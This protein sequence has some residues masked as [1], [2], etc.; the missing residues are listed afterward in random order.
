MVSICNLAPHL[1][2]K[3]T[4]VVFKMLH[5]YILFIQL[6]DGLRDALLF[7]QCP[8]V[9]INVRGR[10]PQKNPTC[11]DTYQRTPRSRK[12]ASLM[13]SGH[14]STRVTFENFQFLNPPRLTRQ[15]LSLTSTLSRTSPWIQLRKKSLRRLPLASANTNAKQPRPASGLNE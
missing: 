2:L 11:W 13:S 6:N 10:L 15:T 7:L 4:S 8:L 14:L 3:L 9:R 5:Q 1:Q 12:L